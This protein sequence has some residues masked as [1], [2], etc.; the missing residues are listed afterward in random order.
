[1]IESLSGLENVFVIA[2][3]ILVVGRG[4]TTSEAMKNHDKCVKK[5]FDRLKEKNIK[6]NFEKIQYKK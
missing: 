4:K 2:D 6:I 3:D 1:M 5:L